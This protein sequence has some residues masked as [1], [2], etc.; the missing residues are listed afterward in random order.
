MS[1]TVMDTTTLSESLSTYIKTPRVRIIEEPDKVI[2]IPQE[3]M[4]LRCN[5]SGRLK[6]DKSIVDE[7]IAEKRAEKEKH[8]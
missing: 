1:T 2:L 4:K 7:Y 6:S 5:L 3:E 8:L